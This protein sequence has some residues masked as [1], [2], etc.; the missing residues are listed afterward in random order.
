[1][2]RVG[3]D[4][5]ARLSTEAA[6]QGFSLNAYCVRKLSGEAGVD[7]WSR[8]GLDRE[9]IEKILR[10]F[11]SEP[12]AV[13]LFG[14]FARNSQGDT[15]DIDLL[16]VFRS[17]TPPT[18][19][20]YRLFDE[21][22]DTSGFRYPVNPHLVSLPENPAD[23]GSLWLETALDGIVL[24]EEG[25]ATSLLLKKV[26]DLITSGRVVRRFAYGQPY[27]V[28]QERPDEKRISG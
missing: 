14:S 11:S 20:M 19:A 7:R 8:L 22:I 2:L 25:H 15:S 27:W 17:D 13:V 28:K 9:F 4:L 1:M 26:R 24:F 6:R 21:K 12:I 18:R 10:I 5:H 23:C 3:P 16:V